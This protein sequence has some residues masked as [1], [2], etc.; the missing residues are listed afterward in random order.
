[1]KWGFM[2]RKFKIGDIVWCTTRE[3]YKITCYHR[4]C[5]VEDYDAFGDLLL[6]AFDQRTETVHDVHEKLFE[7]VPQS[8]IFKAGQLVQIKDLYKPV[9][10]IKYK[11]NSY[12]E[13]L[14]GDWHEEYYIDDILGKE[15]F[16]I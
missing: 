15:E 2:S 16:Y 4:P 5:I 11:N 9:K 12:V 13:V 3:Q 1:M 14:N 10:F 8:M 7:L 6:V